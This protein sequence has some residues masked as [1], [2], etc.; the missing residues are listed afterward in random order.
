MNKLSVPILTD[1][2]TV[3]IRLTLIRGEVQKYL[4]ICLKDKTSL[5]NYVCQFSRQT[6]ASVYVNKILKAY[7]AEKCAG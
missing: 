4:E 2:I 7:S 5:L 1:S 3:E 6:S